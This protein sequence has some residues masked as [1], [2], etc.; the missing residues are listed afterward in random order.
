MIIEDKSGYLKLLDGL[1]KELVCCEPD[2]NDSF[3]V[4]VF[5]TFSDLC[6]SE[7]E[8]KVRKM[9]ATTPDL[10]WTLKTN[11]TEIP[12]YSQSV[13]IF[14]FFLLRYHRNRL[15]ADW[16][17]DRDLLSYTSANIGVSLDN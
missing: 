12:F 4:A 13:I 5:S 10:L 17:L 7:F 8:A 15:I 14:I 6:S 11:R 9:F 1:Y 2:A 16:P 3:T